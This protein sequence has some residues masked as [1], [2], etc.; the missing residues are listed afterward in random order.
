[1]YDIA[2]NNIEELSVLY[3]RILDIDFGRGHIFELLSAAEITAI[4]EEAQLKLPFRL[5]ILQ[6]PIL[7]TT[8]QHIS[9][10]ILIKVHFAVSEITS[11]D[12][13]KVTP[14]PLKIPK[15]S[16]WVLREPRPI[17]AVDYNTQIHF[18]LTD[19]KLKGSIPLTNTNGSEEY[20]LQSKLHYRSSP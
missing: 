16:Y 11:F 4:I 1:M 3:G 14:I 19:D 9:N 7:K 10:E 2:S 20:R 18:E 17:L 6:T 15:T 13:N 12:S 8:V 5:R